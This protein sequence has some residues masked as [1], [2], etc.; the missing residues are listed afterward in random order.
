MRFIKWVLCLGLLLLPVATVSA[1]PN[2]CFNIPNPTA[3]NADK[4]CDFTTNDQTAL[5]SGRWSVESVDSLKS[6]DCP[7]LNDKL[8]YQFASKDAGDLLI[9]RQGTAAVG[10]RKFKRSTTDPD[11][12][13]YT[14]TNRLTSVDYTLKILSP[15]HFT[16]TWM[17]PFKTC[18]VTEDYTLVDADK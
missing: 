13:V 14:R 9:V 11:T 5:I 2:N 1:Q 16:I 6:G 4:S 7:L 17:N 12:Y 18:D 15:E 3:S 10:G 8:P